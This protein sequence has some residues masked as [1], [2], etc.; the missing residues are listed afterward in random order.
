M[1]AAQQQWELLAEQVRK[2]TDPARLGFQTTENLAPTEGLSGQTRA[3]EAIDFALGM[4]DS[5]YNLYVSG[6]PGSGRRTAALKRVRGL[7][8]QQ[9]AATDWCYIYHFD[10]PGEPLAVELPAGAASEFARDV[11]AFVLGCRRELRRAFNGE[12]YRRQRSSTL[13]DIGE[14]QAQLV[15]QLQQ[16]ALAQGFA[17]MGTPQGLTP[18]PLKRAEGMAPG[19]SPHGTEP[20]SPD[21]FAALP[22]DEQQNITQ[23]HR[24]VEEAMERALPQLRALEEEARQRLHTLDRST[25]EQ[26]VAPLATDL[27]ARYTEHERI[28]EY[29]RHMTA[30]IVA[31]ADVLAVPSGE[32][33]EGRPQVGAGDATSRGD[34]ADTMEEH[35]GSSDRSTIGL[36]TD[37][38]LRERPDVAVLVRRYRVNVLI[39]HK[40]DEHAPIVQEINPTYL[41]LLGRIEFGLAG[42][43]PFTDHL[44]IKAGALHRANGGYL[45]L[46][47]QDLLGQPLSWGALKRVLRFGVISIE[48]S[49]EL[50]S[51]PASAALRPEPIPVR[52]KIILIGDP[53]I[54]AALTTLDPEFHQLF[55][56]RADFETD[57]PRTQE[58]EQYY[59]RVAGDMARC[60]KAPP[61]TAEAVALLIEEGSRW[62][63][64]QARLSAGL[65]RLQ[66]L[67]REACQLASQ[68][69]VQTTTRMH[70]SAALAAR[71]R[72]MSLAS[73][74]LDDLILQDTIMIATTGT[75]VGQIN[76]LTVLA[77]ADYAFGKPAR[78]T[79]RTSP[80]VGGIVNLERETMM[81][82]PVHSKGILILSGYLAGT[83]AQDYPLSLVG[84][85]GFEQ[86]YGEIEGDSASSAELY[87]ILSSLAEL[88]I[89][90]ALAVTGSVNQRGEVQAVGGVNE[91]IEGFFKICQARGLTGDQG[92][93][94]PAAN[95]RHLMLREEVV[96]AIR[97]GRF[98]VYAVRTIDEGIE[99]LTGTPAGT[100]GADGMYPA[101]TVNERVSRRLRAFFDLVRVYG[102]MGQASSAARR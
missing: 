84:S 43:L 56:V 58:F 81:S 79:A 7:A 70:L 8:R 28:A 73:D 34:D 19:G 21:E 15:A 22:P 32:G 41:H 54:Y 78:I 36:L 5:R 31:H 57:L 101:H 85:I 14:H 96:D 45:I 39:T 37:A 88:P 40:G 80:G 66:D 44:M 17:L 89:R 16:E 4:P 2:A 25:A 91:K 74:R 24:L 68:E 47:A 76:G 10:K 94:I 98:H 62:A 59:A 46:Q 11:D 64:D 77:T 100:R 6:P 38:D 50:Q 63:G 35:G 9:P 23:Q 27:S 99:L 97:A 42:G 3:E 13:Q 82:G 95:V 69:Q 72:R 52:C 55:T 49:E 18:V 61:L 71:E 48:S 102:A 29:V 92:V 60:G 12:A 87:A 1:A 75:A 67:V 33:T 93:L 51:A 83:Y 30:D 26:A 65:S 20:M 53:D 90:Q 86:V